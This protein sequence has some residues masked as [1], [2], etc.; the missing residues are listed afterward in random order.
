[1]F[2]NLVYHAP[3][4]PSYCNLSIVHLEMNNILVAIKLF[5]NHWEKQGVRIYCDNIAVLPIL[6]S[7]CTQDPYLATCARN[8]CLVATKHHIEIT[9]MQ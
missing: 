3:I 7:G 4:P 9:K 6:Q 5:G 8:G 1:M 2:H